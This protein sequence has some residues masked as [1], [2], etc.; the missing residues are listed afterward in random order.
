[1]CAGRHDVEAFAHEHPPKVVIRSAY[2]A[3]SIP[4]RL[5]EIGPESR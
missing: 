3:G 1:M 4:E 2:Y 5:A